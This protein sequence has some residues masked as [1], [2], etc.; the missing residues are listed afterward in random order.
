[1][2]KFFF[3]KRNRIDHLKQRNPT[4][5]KTTSKFYKQTN[6]QSNCINKRLLLRLPL[7]ISCTLFRFKQQQQQ[8]LSFFKLSCHS[9]FQHASTALQSIKRAILFKKLSKKEKINKENEDNFLQFGN[10]AK[11]ILKTEQKLTKQIYIK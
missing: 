6:K 4:E 10:L 5:T 1:M 11:T 8:Q 9:R 3:F 7:I 2:Q